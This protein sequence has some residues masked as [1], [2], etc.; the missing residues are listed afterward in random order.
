MDKGQHAEAI[1]LL[2]AILAADQIHC[3]AMHDLALCHLAC[4]QPTQA[5]AILERLMKRDSRWAYYRAR[6]P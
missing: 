2:E 1:P 3:E 6:G 4:N 5:V